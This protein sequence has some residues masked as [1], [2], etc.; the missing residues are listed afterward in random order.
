M[1]T[2]QNTSH[3]LFEKDLCTSL[4]RILE[5]SFR[6]F[7]EVERKYQQAMN[8]LQKNLGEAPVANEKEAIHKA[9]SSTLF[10]SVILGIEASRNYY[11]DPVAGDFLNTEPEIYLKEKTARTL[12]D[13][14]AA[15][16]MRRQFYA[17]L[18]NAQRNIYQDVAEYICYLETVGP[19]L[20]HYCG[21][22][23]GNAILQR[24]VPGYDPHIA[25]T[26]R[27][28]MMLENYFGVDLNWDLLMQSIPLIA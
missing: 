6:D 22:L 17:G 9:I 19:K 1:L 13:Y 10:Y 5:N 12:P 20:A 25:V 21:Y 15:Q 23:L 8:E 16:E 27:Y 2:L 18:N 7:P 3:G 11:T 24:I 26:L 4:V 14:E 28:R